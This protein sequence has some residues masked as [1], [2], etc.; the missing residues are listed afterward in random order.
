MGSGDLSLRRNFRGGQAPLGGL[1]PL[2]LFRFFF[3]VPLVFPASDLHVPL[4][5]SAALFAFRS[6]FRSLWGVVSV[7]VYP[8]H[9]MH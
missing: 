2:T 1:V 8:F 5:R 7:L 4:F 6:V 3:C 9:D